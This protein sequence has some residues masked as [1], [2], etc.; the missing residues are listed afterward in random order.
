MFQKEPFMFFVVIILVVA[1]YLIKKSTDAEDHKRIQAFFHALDKAKES[2]ISDAQIQE[3]K[4]KYKT[5]FEYFSKKHSKSQETTN[6]LYTYQNLEGHVAFW[7]QDFQEKEEIKRN[8]EN[9]MEQVS[10]FL[11]EVEELKKNYFSNTNKE[12]LLQKYQDLYHFFTSKNFSQT[13][14]RIPQEFVNTYQHIDKYIIEWN[15]A[16]LRR[17][18]ERLSNFFDNIDG[19]KLDLQQRNAV[20]TDE[21]H[22]LVLAGAGS[23]KTLTIAA[24]VKYLVEQKNIQ[25]E[26]IL[27]I[28]FT[29]KAAEEMNERINQKLSIPVNA[30]TFHKLG[31][32]IIH[33]YQNFTLIDNMKEIV[34]EYFKSIILKDAKA[35]KNMF[36]FFLFYLNVPKDLQDFDCLGS[37]IDNQR[38]LDLIT[39]KSKYNASL[40]ELKIT[41]LK[42][43]LQ[44]VAGERVRSMEEVMIANYLFVN[45]INYEYEKEYPFKSEENPHRSYHPDFYL[46]DYD[47][48]LEHFGINKEGKLPWLSR[49]EEQKYLD[50]MKWKREFHEKN[51]TKLIET[52]S[53]YNQE[54]RLLQKLQELLDE[55]HVVSYPR[56][57]Q[58]IY[59]KVYASDEDYH[60]KEFEKLII[61][62]INLY[63]ANGYTINDLESFKKND[64]SYRTQ[65]NNAFL[66]I[67]QPIL[68]YYENELKRQNGI[69]F[70]DMIN[71]ATQCIQEKE[72][73]FPYQYIIIDEYQDISVGRY[74]LIKEILNHSNAKLMCVGDD[75][76]SIYRFSGSDLDLFSQFEK[77]FGKTAIL[78]I[79]KTYRNSQELLDIAMRFIQKNPEQLHKNLVS[80]KRISQPIMVMAYVQNEK[81]ALQN[82]FTDIYLHFGEE[83]DIL[84]LGR[85]NYDINDY[86]DDHLRYYPATGNVFYSKYP[87][88]KI[89]FMTVHSAKG[90]EADNVIILNMKN[91]LLG[92]PNKISDDEVLS[93]VLQNKDTY[94]YA[95]ERRLFYVAMTRTKNK[96]YLIAPDKNQSLFLTDLKGI[97]SLNVYLNQNEETVTSNSNCPRCKKGYLVIRDGKDGPFLGCTNY[98]YCNYHL[99][100]MD[101]LKT[102]IRCK[103]CGGY[104]V[105]RHGKYGEFLGCSNYPYCK[106]TGAKNKRRIGFEIY[107]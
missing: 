79:E 14:L 42:H 105:R 21:D 37:Y 18:V 6:F 107:G 7:N 15:F 81:L 17:E 4:E 12:N 33:Q 91:S 24:K 28:S 62:F 89:R 57:I 47:I 8:Y 98:P 35:L 73:T 77:Y 43:D 25:P 92:F 39:L 34:S 82:A 88:M 13:E 49:V 103:Q 51:G 19:K 96:T 20:L 64:N 41:D 80:D 70:S 16:F 83:A 63:K 90:L 58:D 40:L 61:T 31:N 67:I 100:N 99:K 11:S 32:D 23:G 9:R 94:D 78:K 74:K 10:S 84:L 46:T 75:W 101:V 60:F 53:Y 95:E 27:L 2:F 50:E 93:M 59:E 87:K 30:V 29:K 97:T 54:R 56:D 66:D 106:N 5:L 52:Y 38:T 45:G 85:T 1:F 69:D 76:Q 104:L 36:D 22:N 26:D 55:N 3:I 65:R 72:M 48:Y 71:L 44:T 102:Q 86:V 68:T